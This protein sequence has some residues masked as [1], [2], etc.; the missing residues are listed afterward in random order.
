MLISKIKILAT[1]VKIM[2]TFLWIKK[3]EAIAFIKWEHKNK[4]IV[5]LK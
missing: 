4:I 2:I 5:F 1:H 3:N